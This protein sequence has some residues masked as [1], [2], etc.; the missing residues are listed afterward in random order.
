MRKLFIKKNNHGSTLLTV[1][2]CLALVS[3]LGSL[4][5]SAT[6]TNLQ[7]KMV[8]SKSKRN[9]YSCEIAMEEIR[10][11]LEELAATKIREVYETDILNNFAAY[12]T[13]PED[14][15]ND[16]IKKLVAE[17]ILRELGQ[18]D[19]IASEDLFTEAGILPKIGDLFDLY[20]TELDKTEASLSR[21]IS[22][23]GDAVVLKDI[24]VKYTKEDYETT[25]TSDIVITLPAFTFTNGTETTIYRMEAPF[26]S[27]ALVSDGQ[28]RSRHTSGENTVIGSV[29]AGGGITVDSQI[30]ESHTLTLQGGDIISR[31]DITAV[32]TGKLIIKG[33][34]LMDGTLKLPVIWADNLKT[35]TTSLYSAGFTKPTTIEINGVCLV[36]DDLT[37]EGSNSYVVLKGAYVGYT[38][39]HTAEGSAIMIN[40]TGST[41]DL[42]DLDSL[43]LA[44]RA[45]ISVDD[46][47][48]MEEDILTGES[49]AWKSN[50]R[51]YLI[52]GKFITGINHNPI[53]QSDIGEYNVPNVNFTGVPMDSTDPSYLNYVDPLHPYKIA[54]KQ[55]IEGNSSTILRYYY[56]DFLSG[57]QA[58]AYLQEF[59]SKKA[60]V[61]NFMEPFTLGRVRLPKSSSEV[62]SVGNL[63]S[64][65]G[66][67]VKLQNGLSNSYPSD[68]LASNP[69]SELDQAIRQLKLDD[70]VY[71]NAGLDSGN[72]VG[73]LEAL[74]SKITHLLSLQ[75]TKTYRD[76][77]KVVASAVIS[78]GVRWIGDHYAGY[79]GIQYYG[80]DKVIDSVDVISPDSFLVIHGD[81]TINTNINGFVIASGNITIGNHV[82]ING[83]V[84]SSGERD[85]DNQLISGGNITVGDNV[86]V[87]GRII[88]AGN[89]DLGRNDS[90]TAANDTSLLH[91]FEL[92][93]EVLQNLFRNAEMSINFTVTEPPDNL[94]DLSAMISYE[95]WRKD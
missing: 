41:L 68:P 13:I 26:Q 16:K 44:G 78:G 31:G 63:M 4:I 11:G 66:V 60:P 91:V 15:R 73:M 76:T 48:R 87:N 14:Q 61:L 23:T 37:L 79:T 25:I 7:M 93:G 89:I 29:Y 30:T 71:S 62:A 70:T 21:I 5:L 35:K 47:V 32:D 19:G 51:A 50:Q 72:S 94:V 84:I 59:I 57:K 43:I 82:T 95:N 77:D 52:P 39:L 36:K 10:T 80:S 2:I 28:I 1:I 33:S 90:F 40:G 54:A 92:Q 81:A 65:D 49:V 42:Y 22:S 53:T 64:Y 18:T 83:M 3:I 46:D 55:T 86:T 67:E 20:L 6:M 74:Y 17:K 27:F 58:D 34:T 12:L 69:D 56:L 85:H 24:C 9:F 8:E 75:S 88:A 38:G 45:H